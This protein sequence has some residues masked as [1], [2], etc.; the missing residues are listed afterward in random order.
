M[1]L[2][3]GVLAGGA[4]AGASGTAPVLAWSDEFTAL[5]LDVALNGSANWGWKFI[6]FDANYLQFNEDEAWKAH[7]N[8]EP[9]GA[10][11]TP[12]EMGVVLHEVSGGTLKLYGRL[13]PDAA[14][15]VGF[16]YL[17]GMITG[18]LSHLREFGTWECR[19]RFTVTKGQHWAMW[20]ITKEYFFAGNGQWPELDMVEVVNTSGSTLKLFM[21]DHAN[22]PANKTYFNGTNPER[23][24]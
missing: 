4:L 14:S 22:P 9:G 1:T 18:E 24:S 11:Q 2:S 12:A 16:P 17:G 10:G 8:Y 20:L 19:A 7:A 13:N 6:N 5:S 3:S 23:Q 21:N 15:Y